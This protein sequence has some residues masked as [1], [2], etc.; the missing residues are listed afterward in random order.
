MAGPQ[1]I[2][3]NRAPV[4]TLWAAV[5]AQWLGFG[6]ED[7]LRLGKAVPRAVRAEGSRAEGRTGAR[8]KEEGCRGVRLRAAAAGGVGRADAGA[9]A[10]ETAMRRLAMS[11]TRTRLAAKAKRPASLRR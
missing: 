2:S 7:A 9:A 5:V 10:V 3:I 6:R 8:E 1:R 4:L 11:R